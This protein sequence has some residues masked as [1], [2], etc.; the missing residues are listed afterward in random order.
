MENGREK[1]RKPE[2]RSRLSV[3]FHWKEKTGSLGSYMP[4]TFA[5]FN[6]D[7]FAVIDHN[8]DYKSF[9]EFCEP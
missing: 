9:V 1:I 8:H 3:Q 4:F 6:L 5:N 2:K 7:P